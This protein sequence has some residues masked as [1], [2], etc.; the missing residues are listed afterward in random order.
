MDRNS[1]SKV[2]PIN[3]IKQPQLIN[4]AVKKGSGGN[5]ASNPYLSFRKK[6]RYDMFRK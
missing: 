1:K 4:P 2:S 6:L 3:G 5:S